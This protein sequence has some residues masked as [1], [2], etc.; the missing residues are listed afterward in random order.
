MAPTFQELNL[1]VAASSLALIAAGQVF[2]DAL[3][4]EVPNG[5]AIVIGDQNEQLQTLMT[6]S[7]EQDRLSSKATYANFLGG[8]AILE[9]FRADALDVATVGN[10]PPIQAQAAG[11][12]VPIV[13]AVKIA[14]TDY[15]L[16]CGPV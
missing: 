1:T 15:E 8:P 16:R 14:E 2:A 3:P 5:T 9:A 6:A 12:E 11:Q 10:V 7:G 4:T 13:A